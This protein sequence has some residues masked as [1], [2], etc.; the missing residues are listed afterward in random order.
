MR[1]MVKGLP[2]AVPLGAGLPA[3]LQEDAFLQRF[4]LAF[5]DA[6]APVFTTL[7]GLDAY[8][9]PRLAPEDFL[10]WL[11]EW[12]G[13]RLD[14]SWTTARRRDV[15]AHAAAIHRRRGTLPGV[16]DAVRLAVGGVVDVEVEDNGGVVW[17]ST[18]GAELPGRAAAMLHVRVYAAARED[19]NLRRLEGIIN[20]VKPAHVPHTLEIVPTVAP[21]AD[22]S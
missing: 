13:V 15:V 18:P 2:S 7:D 22:D 14:E 3:V 6:L 1:G 8:L 20:A 12:V 9:N 10:N 5:D 17:S 11:A 16:A 4:L 19:V 21:E